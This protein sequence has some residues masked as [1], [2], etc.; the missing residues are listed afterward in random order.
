MKIENRETGGVLAYPAVLIAGLLM[1]APS[2]AQAKKPV[3]PQPTQAAPASLLPT[4]DFSTETVGSEPS[5]LKTVVG[6]WSI[7]SEG[8]NKYVMVDGSKWE[9][10]NASAGV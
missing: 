10:G 2:W 8:A 4:N 9:E 1:A 5:T 7:G 6:N 3:P